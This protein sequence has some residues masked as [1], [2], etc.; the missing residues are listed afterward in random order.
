MRGIVLISPGSPDSGGTRPF[1]AIRDLVRRHRPECPIE[2]AFIEPGNPALE[3]AVATLVAEGASSIAVFPLLMA[4]GA[5][6][7]RDLPR[8]VEAARAKHPHVPIALEAALG[9]VPEVLEG[10][11]AWIVRRAD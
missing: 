1:E 6:P 10:I 11:A 2:V 8:L 5:A 3:E 9:D 7:K 4:P